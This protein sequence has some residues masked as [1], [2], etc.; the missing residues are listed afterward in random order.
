MAS[1]G[2]GWRDRKLLLDFES[3]A[4]SIEPSVWEQLRMQLIGVPGAPD[5]VLSRPDSA[6]GQRPGAGRGARRLREG[7]TRA[8]AVPDPTDRCHAGLPRR[9][10]GAADRHLAG[11]WQALREA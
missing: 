9:G 3:D 6:L 8:A 7:P 5:L 2:T 11:P 10:R 1:P 4:G